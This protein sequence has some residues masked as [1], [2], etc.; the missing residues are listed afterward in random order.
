MKRLSLTCLVGILTVLAV[1]SQE[2]WAQ[3]GV[4]GGPPGLHFPPGDETTLPP[5]FPSGG[6]PPGYGPVPNGLPDVIYLPEGG[7]TVPNG[8]PDI[9]Y[10]YP[11]PGEGRT[12]WTDWVN[13]DLPDILT[14]WLKAV[15]DF[16]IGRWG[17]R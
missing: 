2:T 14:E 5:V 12:R 3:V 17:K 4:P 1:P 7:S 11:E 8:L 13:N 15:P 6:F 10:I 9:I 16:I